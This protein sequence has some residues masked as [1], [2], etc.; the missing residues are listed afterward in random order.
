MLD[1]SG[2]SQRARSASGTALR[3]L[4]VSLAIFVLI[5]TLP[6]GCSYDSHFPSEGPEPERLRDSSLRPLR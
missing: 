2:G 4:P 1:D 5:T 3:A 6:G